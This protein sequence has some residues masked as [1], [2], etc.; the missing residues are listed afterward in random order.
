MVFIVAKCPQA[1]TDCLIRIFTVYEKQ[2]MEPLT[3][4]KLWFVCLLTTTGL[5][6]TGYLV[7]MLVGISFERHCKPLMLAF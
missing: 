5:I 1:V 6:Q 3:D 2:L 4:T 7:E